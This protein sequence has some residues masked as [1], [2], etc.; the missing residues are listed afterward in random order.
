MCVCVGYL[1]INMTDAINMDHNLLNV[2][3]K[4]TSAKIYLKLCH[5]F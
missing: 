1:S 2:I 3:L 4:N 5:M